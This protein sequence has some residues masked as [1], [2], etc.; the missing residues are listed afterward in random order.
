MI[1]CV[2]IDETLCHSIEDDYAHSQPAATAIAKVN[3]LYEA[4]HTIKLFTGR[5]SWDNYDW[6]KFTEVQLAKWGVKYHELI[7]GKP[8]A[9]VFID[10]KA[11]NAR[12][13][14]MSGPEQVKEVSRDWG[15][16]V[17]LINCDEYC[18]KLLYLPKGAQ[19]GEHFHDKKKETFYCLKGQVILKIAGREVILDPLSKP[20]TV[21]P[22]EAHSF[23]GTTHSLILEISTH[24]SEDDVTFISKGHREDTT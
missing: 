13:W 1:Y 2:D 9:D 16:E 7:L 3:D 15:K 17:W 22:G 18:G 21:M 11:L 14:L 4:G 19:A 5:G 10:D 6:R 8:H 12:D 23:F 24:H 20:M